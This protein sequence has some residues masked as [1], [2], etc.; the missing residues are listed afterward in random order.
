MVRAIRF[1]TTAKVLSVGSKVTLTEPVTGLVG[2]TA[3]GN[4]EKFAAENVY[5]VVIGTA[6]TGETSSRVLPRLST[7]QATTRR[8]QGMTRL[9]LLT[10]ATGHATHP[11]GAGRAPHGTRMS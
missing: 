10:E 5:R 1:T 3:A 9:L 8:S 6:A 4:V 11:R 2:A 7:A